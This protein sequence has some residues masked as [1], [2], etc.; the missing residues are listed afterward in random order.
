MI[1]SLTAQL[2]TAL[3]YNESQEL[4]SF[5]PQWITIYYPIEIFG[6]KIKNT[7]NCVKTSTLV[8]RKL[9]WS[10][11]IH[12]L[13]HWIEK[14][15]SQ[16]FKYLSKFSDFDLRWSDL[17]NMQIWL[18]GKMDNWCFGV[19]WLTC[20]MNTFFIYSVYSLHLT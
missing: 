8:R 1:V 9:L 16:N 15:K 14:W 3:S 6:L 20:I 2:I 10:K 19:S 11:K 18:Q 5:L 12:I 7:V 17:I 4:Q 13:A